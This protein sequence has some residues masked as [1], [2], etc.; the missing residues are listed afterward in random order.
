MSFCG[1]TPSI[2]ASAGIFQVAAVPL[3]Q[4]TGADLVGIAPQSHVLLQNPTIQHTLTR[5][6]S[7]QCHRCS[8]VQTTSASQHHSKV[9]LVLGREKD[10]H[11]QQSKC[12][13]TSG[14]RTDICSDGRTCP[15]MKASK[16][17]TQGECPEVES[18]YISGK[19][20]SV[21]VQ[22]PGSPRQAQ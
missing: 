1:L 11:I 7:K 20:W 12:D 19:A 2:L 3:I 16:G 17:T 15:P 9:I 14:L 10:N 5:V 4:R 22:A 18:Y 21:S 13:P 6:H 8:S